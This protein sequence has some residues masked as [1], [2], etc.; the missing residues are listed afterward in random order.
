MTSLVRHRN[1]RPEPA[2]ERLDRLAV[3]GLLGGIAVAGMLF[4]PVF[5][6][7]PLLVPV[8]AVLLVGYGCVE[9]CEAWPWA[10]AWRPIVV[11]VAGL[12]GV[13]E[14]ML[15][16][17][18]VVG[19]PTGA[20]LAGIGRGFSTAW[21][22]TLQS[23]WPARPVADQL[24]FV[25]LV[26]LCAVVVGLELLLLLRKPVVALLPGL[27]V[28]GLAQVYQALS[29]I[30]G[31]FAVIGYA[32]SAGLVLWAQRPS[33]TGGPRRVSVIGLRRVL[34]I[35]VVGV[36]GAVS[37]GGFDPAGRQPYRLQSDQVAPLQQHEISDPLDQVA[38]RLA[39]PDQVVFRYASA[40]PVDRWRLAVL[41]GFDGVDWSADL[42]LRRLGAGLA[43]APGSTTRSA[44]VRLTGLAGPW[45][46]S[47][48][49]PLG[50]TGVVPLIDQAT[51]TLLQDASAPSG[52]QLTWAEPAIDGGRLE[53]AAVDGQAPGGLGTVPAGMDVLARQAVNGMPPSFQAALQLERFLATN[54]QVAT[55][56]DLPTGHSWPQL[57]YFLTNSKRGTS[58]QFATAYVVL[59][60]LAGIPARVVVGFRGTDQTDNGFHVVRNRDVL[61]WPEVAVAGVGWVPLDP[62]AGATQSGLPRSGGGAG[63]AG[64]VAAARQQLPSTKDL[65]PAQSQPD[66]TVVAPSPSVA[67]RQFGLSV[68][69]V[70]VTLLACWL[71]GVPLAVWARARTRRRRA[72]VDG[73]IGAWAEARDRLRAHGVPY[74]IGMTPRDMAESGCAVVGARTTE[75]INKLARVVDMALWSGVLVTD[76]AARRAW[77][78]VGMI[79]RGLAA[80]PWQVRLRAAVDP[81]ALLPPAGLRPGR[82]RSWLRWPAGHG[83]H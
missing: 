78:E 4:T 46:P 75:S 1:R 50:V 23:T 76:A 40:A 30:A 41:S 77:D 82:T 52:Y 63:L 31:M 34:L 55:G 48:P 80:R 12:L 28:V 25:P 8:L 81:R 61:A 39:D 65:H 11:L 64:A 53:A 3:A 18:T 33:R 68:A 69:G 6:A 26:V 16:D 67:V 42:Q 83:P 56:D 2:G 13:I 72:G 44:E 10:G 38:D 70:L 57:D 36:V 79:R 73:V 47:Q 29:G 20:S 49:T 27:A 60:R 51:G 9:L 45:L 74:R 19:L 7:G 14:S 22:L 5:G 54:Y 21:S 62:T 17:T 37:V 15:F 66:K 43:A 35:V 58:E 71:A 59:A 32:A 24:L